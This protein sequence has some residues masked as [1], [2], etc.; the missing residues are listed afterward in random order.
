MRLI[1]SG[2]FFR[3]A[4]RS[5]EDSICNMMKPNS[6]DDSNIH[7]RSVCFCFRNDSEENYQRKVNYIM[8]LTINVLADE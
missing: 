2:G 3:F 6:T 8:L 5:D 1:P 7:C 4:N